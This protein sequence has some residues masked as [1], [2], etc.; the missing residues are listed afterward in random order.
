MLCDSKKEEDDGLVLVLNRV[1]TSQ[2]SC[3]CA[4]LGKK[5]ADLDDTGAE[6]AFRILHRCV[7]AQ[8]YAWI[9]SI[10]GRYAKDGCLAAQSGPTIGKREGGQLGRPRPCSAF[11]PVLCR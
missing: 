9:G 8:E 10:G 3:M 11:L 7:G 5:P 6:A 2:S 4:S 1:P